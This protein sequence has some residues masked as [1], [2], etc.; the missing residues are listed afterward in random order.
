MRRIEWADNKRIN[1]SRNGRLS[2]EHYPQLKIKKEYERIRKQLDE[3]WE[4]VKEKTVCPVDLNTYFEQEEIAGKSL[5]TINIGSCDL[6][7]GNLLVRDPLVYLPNRNERPYFQNAPAGKYETEICVIKS[8]DEDCDRYAAVRLRFNE[9][10]AVRFY[11]ALVGNENLETLEE[12]DY[13]GFCVDAGL[14][15][16]C[17]EIIHRIY[18][19]WD[20]QWRKDNPDDNPYDG[21]FAALFKENY[22]LHPEY[23][24]AGGDWLNWQVPGTEYHIPIFQSGFGDG[25]YP[26]YWGIDEGGE[27]CQLVIQFIDIELAYGNDEEN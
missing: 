24:R 17:D 4:S 14:G 3:K 1:C 6:P 8:D 9:K 26:V 25:T 12:G 11:E 5:T 18:C 23:Q 2:T 19:D 22:Y 15:C 21:Y 13:F 16:V 27:I 7:S 10:R 20:E